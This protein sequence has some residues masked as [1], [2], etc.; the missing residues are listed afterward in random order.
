MERLPLSVNKSNLLR[1][2]DE[3]FFARDGLEL[4]D[5]KKEAL[6][7][8]INTLAGKAERVRAKMNAMLEE[9]YSHLREAILVDGRLACERAA[10]ASKMGEEVRVREKS[11]MGVALPIV[12]IDLPRFVPSYGFQG[13]GTAMDAVAKTIQGGMEIIAELAE[14]EVGLFRLIAEIKKT[15]KRINALENIYIPVYESTI[16]HMEESLEE[17][18]REFLF[19]MKRQKGRRREVEHGSI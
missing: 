18:E 16:K 4:L 5:E 14:I 1:L 10:L 15:I 19:Q 11:F 9:A 12:R 3:L 13:T 7:A 2:K 8:H 17:K 6:M